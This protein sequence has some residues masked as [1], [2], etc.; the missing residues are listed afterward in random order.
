MTCRDS[1]ALI[2][3]ADC[4]VMLTWSDW[5]NEP[6]SNRYHFAT[7][8]A[9]LLPVLFVQPDAT[10][11]EATVEDS[12]FP[13]IRL[14]HIPPTYGAA[15]TALLA[16]AVNALGFRRPL[17]W[18]YNAHF[19]DFVARTFSPLKIYHATEDYFVPA[20]D[21]SDQL[22]TKLRD[23]LAHT[24]LLVTVSKSL[25]DRYIDYGRY[26]GKALVL[27]NGCDYQ[28]WTDGLTDVGKDFQ[29]GKPRAIYQ[30]GINSRLDFDL[31]AG[32]ARALPHWDFEFCGRVSSP[33]EGWAALLALQN[34]RFLGELAP[35]EL[36]T[37]CRRATV[38][39]IPFK[40]EPYID[41][42]MP[43]KALEY[44]ASGLPVV[45]VP[46]QAL[47]AF[48]KLFSIANDASGFAS[49]LEGAISQRYDKDATRERQ[50]VASRFDYDKRFQELLD[51]IDTLPELKKRGFVRANVLILYD[52]EISLHVSTIE[53]HLRSFR[54]FSTHEVLYA[55]ASGS[56][57][58]TYDLSM[59]D[60]VV[61][62]YS[63]RVSTATHLSRDYAPALKAYGGLKLLFLQDEYEGTETARQW[64]E[65]LGVHVVFTCVPMA[66][67]EKV[68]PRSRFPHVEFLP[69]LTGYV[70]LGFPSLIRPLE[71]RPHLIAYRG[72]SLPYWYGD[73]G[74]EK[75]QIGK[76]MKAICAERGLCVDIAWQDA[77]RIYGPD[78]Y[79]FL[80]SARATL[81]TESGANV[82]DEHGAIRVSIEAAGRENP[83]LDYAEARA[84]FLGPHEGRVRMNQVSPKIFEAIACRTALVLFEG[85]YSGVVKPNV[86]YIP[87]KKD[88]SNVDEVLKKLQDDAFISALT[89]RA[90]A[91]V[92]GTGAFSYETFV[93]DVDRIIAE[94]LRVTSGVR[95]LTE[96]VA[97][98]GSIGINWFTV[99][100][101]HGFFRLPASVV[102]SKKNWPEAPLT[103][104]AARDWGIPEG[105]RP[106][107]LLALGLWRLLPLSARVRARPFAMRALAAAR[108]VRARLHGN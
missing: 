81:G 26:R 91:D 50:T 10:N 96:V 43:L 23:I 41:V 57:K 44:V 71:E 93:H 52:A 70:P 22:V 46:I 79:G 73:L 61:L 48:P 4:V 13:N 107:L 47:R 59:F 74:Q 55:H 45:S 5:K 83:S 65:N 8:F 32:L 31:L 62:H 21:P 35:E 97:T 49:A 92:I 19:H 12:G 77:E 98:K 53:E 15:Q 1:G 99:P 6:R 104:E 39:L 64:I 82:F 102:E 85:E 78:W 20:G 67:V 33:G 90:Y 103:L 95:V 11:A 2:R 89:E 9:K 69:T 72:R 87:L 86:H 42:S 66:D 29:S 75:L 101:P 36:R 54:I 108:Q 14:V 40:Q 58:C 56:A 51:Q 30:G 28:F 25:R 80:Q 105:V 3:R 27:M 16:G 76:R 24:D 94:R 60:A 17:L 106:S 68:Y 38:G 84:R 88:F 37:A 34:V 100:G 63:I 18:T 7:R